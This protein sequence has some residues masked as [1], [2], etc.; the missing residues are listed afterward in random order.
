MLGGV[1]NT[2]SQ[3]IPDFTTCIVVAPLALL[4][5]IAAAA[6]ASAMKRRGVRAPFTRKTFHFLIISLAP[7]V[8][9]QFGPAGVAVYAG[10]VALLVLGAVAKGKGFAFYDAL[11]RPS[12]EPRASLFIIVPLITTA[13]GG[14]LANIF[15]PGW[16]HIGY[17]AVA[18]GDAVGEPVGTRW[19][20]HRYRVPSIGGVPAHRSIEGS[21]AV[22]VACMLGALVLLLLGDVAPARAIGVAL[23]TGVACAGVEAVSHHGTDNLTVQVAAAAVVTWLLG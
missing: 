6:I 5:G 4:Y 20:K 2:L 18:W 13:L 11:A 1:P 17:M 16:A 7:L 3:F 23:I 8:Q 10:V 12:D 19:G 9:M 22:L 21:A 14:I 15:F